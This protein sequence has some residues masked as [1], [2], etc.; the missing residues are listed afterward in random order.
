MSVTAVRGR[1]G[2]TGAK[3]RIYSS[4]AQEQM[5]KRGVTAVRVEEVLSKGKISPGNVAGRTVYD[6][7]PSASSSGRGVRVVIDDATGRI[8]TVIDKGSK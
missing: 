8:I 1:S 3:S 2:I 4:H 5:A 6:I 7:A